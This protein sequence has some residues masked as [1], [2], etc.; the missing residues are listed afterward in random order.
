M[1]KHVNTRVLAGLLLGGLICAASCATINPRSLEE[2]IFKS[3]PLDEATVAAGLKDALRV[4][5]ERTANG[6]SVLDGFLGNALIR[7]ALP[8]EF[9]DMAGALRTVGFGRQVDELEVA[10]NRAAERAAGEAKGVFWDAIKRM[11]IADAFAILRGDDDAATR[12]FR[13]ATED[14]L[15]SRFGPIVH[16]K[17]EEVGLYRIYQELSGYYDRIPLVKKPAVD[18]DAYVTDRALGGLFTVLALEEKRIREDPAARTTELLRRV[19][20]RTDP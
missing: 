11:S 9:H 6:V 19:F 16:A 5:T 20:G 3:G 18:L 8:E 17:M 13:N 10:M 2:A 1:P 4:G 7:I 12:Y 14:E 15:R